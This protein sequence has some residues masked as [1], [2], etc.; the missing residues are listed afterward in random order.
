[1]STGTG[2]NATNTSIVVTPLQTPLG[3]A[4]LFGTARGLL[5]VALP[6]EMRSFTESWLRRAARG[7]HFV[8]DPAALPE[9][10][11]QLTAYFAGER[12]TFDLPLDWRGTPFQRAVWEAVCA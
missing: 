10:R 8:E 5:M 1:M 2:T 6:G 11:S 3:T 12:R 4:R 9:A 7:A